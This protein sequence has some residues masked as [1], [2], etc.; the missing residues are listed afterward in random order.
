M[1]WSRPFFPTPLRK[2]EKSGL[3]TQ[4]YDNPYINSRLNCAEISYFDSVIQSDSAQARRSYVRSVCVHSRHQPLSI[5]DMDYGVLQ[6][7]SATYKSVPA[8]DFRLKLLLL[9]LG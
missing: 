9:V 4:D 1:N 2:T 5:F 8:P 3:A 6:N 7:I